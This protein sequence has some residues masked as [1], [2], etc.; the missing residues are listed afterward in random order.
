MTRYNTLTAFVIGLGSMGKRRVRNLRALGVERILGTDLRDDRRREAVERYGIEAVPSVERGLAQHPDLVIISTPPHRH[1]EFAYAAIQAGLPFF[2]EANCFSEGMA[3]LIDA[4]R[5]KSLVAAPS[6]TL[7]F[8]EGVRRVKELLDAGSLGTPAEFMHHCG[9]ALPQWHPWEDYRSFYGGQPEAKGAGWDMVAFESHLFTHWFGDV[10]SVSALYGKRTTFNTPVDDT[11]Q[12][13]LEFRAGTL[14]SAM[15]DVISPYAFRTTRIV[16][17]KGVIAFDDIKK[18]VD[19]FTAGSIDWTHYR[20]E[21][22]HVEPGYV[23]SEEMYI[24][25]IE[26]FLKAVLGLAPYV[27]TF[28]DELKLMRI[29]DAVRESKETGRLIN[30]Q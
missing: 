30:L 13:I 12:I 19:L 16:S 7:W 5:G 8:N 9:H 2:M 4:L 17:E 28:E 29:V 10:K 27:A 23:A 21:P 20:H 18:T 6:R 11:F 25:E 14:G 1:L 15:I 26:A 3:G 24:Q 22:G